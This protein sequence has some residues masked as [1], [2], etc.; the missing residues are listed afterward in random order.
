M[1]QT[2]EFDPYPAK[3]AIKRVKIEFYDSLAESIKWLIENQ[4]S[5]YVLDTNT[6][7]SFEKENFPF[8]T[9]FIIGHEEFGVNNEIIK[10]FKHKKIKIKQFGE[11]ES[12]NVSIATS[13]AMYE[14]TKQ[15]SSQ[16]MG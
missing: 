16:V 5:I 10:N 13:I 12:L 14:Y 9:A 11:T 2:K 4:Y 15:V 1:V 3:G 6:E 8:K 7:C